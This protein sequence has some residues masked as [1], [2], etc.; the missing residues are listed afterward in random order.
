MC[1]HYEAPEPHTLR[2]LFGTAPT[3]YKQDLWPGYHGAFV[4]NGPAGGP[5]QPTLEVLP[6]VFGLLPFWAKDLTLA[7]RTY[8]ARS[9]TVAEKA[10]FRSAWARAQHCVIPATAIYEP[11]WRSGK[12]VPTRI[13]RKDGSV[14]NIAGLWER[15]TSPVGEETFSFT[16]LTVNA[17]DHPFMSRYHRLDK[18]KRMVVILPD[19]AVTAWLQSTAESSSAFMRQYPA[20]RLLAE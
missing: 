19:D 17:D 8:N 7:R 10:A 14:M 13:S 11:D 9:E 16:M 18:E 1:S 3:E 5:D 20:D 4:R 12:A 6:G 15:W 2:A